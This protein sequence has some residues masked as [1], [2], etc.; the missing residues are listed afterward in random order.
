MMLAQKHGMFFFSETFVYYLFQNVSSSK[1][2]MFAKSSNGMLMFTTKTFLKDIS[3]NIQITFI[4]FEDI[5]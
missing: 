3:E 2:T 5:S 4:N 1:V